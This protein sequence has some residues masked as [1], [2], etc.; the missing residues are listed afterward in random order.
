M[1]Q[2]EFDYLSTPV[3]ELKIVASVKG[4]CGIL[5]PDES[6]DRVKFGEMKQNHLNPHIKMAK[7]QLK[8]YFA[9]QRKS[10]D[11]TIDLMGTDFQK[12]V[13]NRLHEISFGETKTYVQIA[14]ELHNPKASR[15]VGNSNRKN[16]ISI[17]FPCHRVIG[18]NGKLTGYAGGLN[19]KAWLLNFERGF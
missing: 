7:L 1:T 14:K 9:R 15:A 5:W 10:F 2:L 17:V 6:N 3:G 8:E 13:W 18:T 12:K 19:A 11:L 16:P 4:L